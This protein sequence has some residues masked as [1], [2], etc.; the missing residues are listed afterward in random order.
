MPRETRSLRRRLICLI[1]ALVVPFFSVGPAAAVEPLRIATFQVD[2]TPPLGAPLCDSLCPPASEIVDPLSARGVV[3]VADAQPIVLCAVDWVGIGNGAYDAWRTTIAAAAGTVTSRVA[4]HCLHQHD[5]PGCDFEAEE[6]LAEQGLS[7]ACFHVAF[8][9]QAIERVAT[10]VREAKGHLQPLTHIG[11]GIGRV[12][13]VA[14]NRRILGP[15][16]KVKFVRYS[17][18]RE[19]EVRAAPE[20]VIDPD[21]RLIAL[22][23][24]DRA[25][26]SLTYYATHPQSYYGAGGVSAD[27]VGMARTLREKALPDLAHIHFNGASGNVAAGK[28]NDGSREMRP[29]LAER[30]AAGMQRAWESSKKTPIQAS[31]VSWRNVAVALPLR[32]TLDESQ[33]TATLRDTKADVRERVR[34]ARDLAWLRRCRQGNKIELSYLRLGSAYVVHMP[35]ELFVEYQLAAERLKPNNLVCLAAY[36]DYGPGYI[37]TSIAYPQ[38]GYET[39][40]VSRVGPEVEGMLMGALE[41]LLK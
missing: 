23:N 39:S 7:G 36:G 31:D 22:F 24:G 13:Q 33:L 6:L 27:F 16:G 30:L 25:I 10:A 11:L 14:S 19:E 9:H 2:V 28:Y 20:G 17:S 18:C 3:L 4:V 38:G 40:R 8:A 34:A 37:G 15:D 41:E 32:D 35:G 12:E 21:C 26:V 1:G 5:A 29:V